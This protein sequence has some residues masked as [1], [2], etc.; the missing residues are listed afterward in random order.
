[1]YSNIILDK[2]NGITYS[3]NEL[4]N[5]YLST[6]QLVIILGYLIYRKNFTHSMDATKGKWLDEFETPVSEDEQEFLD[7]LEAENEEE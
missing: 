4:N 1:M 5:G 2:S 6:I 7:E 3:Q